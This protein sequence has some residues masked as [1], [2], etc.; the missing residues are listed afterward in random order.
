MDYT[1]KIVTYKSFRNACEVTEWI[2]KQK[3]VTIISITTEKLTKDYT[4]Y[5]IFYCY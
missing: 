3:D 2:N 1:D 4:K 5:V